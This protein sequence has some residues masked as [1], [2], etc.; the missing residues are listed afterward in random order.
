MQSYILTYCRPTLIKVIREGGGE[1]V[2]VEGRRVGGGGLRQKQNNIQ[3][4][5][6][7][8]QAEKGDKTQTD[9]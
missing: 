7:T 5:W 8:D 2:C 6:G 1:C 9:R 3:T 4:E